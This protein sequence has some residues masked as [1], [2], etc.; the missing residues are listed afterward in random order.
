MERLSEGAGVGAGDQE[1]SLDTCYFWC[2]MCLRHPGEGGWINLG[3]GL[4]MKMEKTSLGMSI[5]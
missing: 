1:S 5:N 2:L 3:L 4:R